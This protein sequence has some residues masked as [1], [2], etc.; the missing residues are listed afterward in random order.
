MP[1]SD[2]LPVAPDADRPR[3]SPIGALVLGVFVVMS[4]ILVQGV[5]A[6]LLVATDVDVTVDG[7]ITFTKTLPIAAVQ[8]AGVLAVAA[9][10]AFGFSTW[11]RI[12]VPGPPGS[13]A[14]GWR[15][16]LP[17]GVLVIAP[18]VGVAL[19]QDVPLIDPHV[20]PTLAAALIVLAL[21]I[22]INEELW[23]RGLLVDALETARRPWLTIIGSAVLFG[24]PHVGDSTVYALNAVAVTLAV[25]IP[26]TVVRLRCGSL[27]PLIAWHAIVDAWAFLHTASVTPQGSPDVGDV[28]ATLVLPALVAIGYLWWYLRQDL[29]AAP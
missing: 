7:E 27:G 23:F 26:F 24:L 3:R 13:F 9:L 25:G 19:A 11:R 1:D 6:A 16:L 17:V 4:F 29:A 22:A 10:V 28:V 12:A 20:T 5:V 14:A 2:Q 8:V 21:L 15:A 18:T